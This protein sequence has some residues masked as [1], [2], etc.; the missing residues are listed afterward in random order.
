[1]RKRGERE[2]WNIF[3]VIVVVVLLLFQAPLLVL[4][5]TMGIYSPVFSAQA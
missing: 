1:M 2:V 4:V 3:L 5:N